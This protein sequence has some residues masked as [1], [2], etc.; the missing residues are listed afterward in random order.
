MGSRQQLSGESI[1]IRPFCLKLLPLNLVTLVRTF[2]AMTLR[3]ADVPVAGWVDDVSV[4]LRNAKPYIYAQ[5]FGVVADQHMIAFCERKVDGVASL[6]LT[7]SI[8]WEF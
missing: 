7:S 4:A 8:A 6:E 2:V 1:R 3:T 5:R